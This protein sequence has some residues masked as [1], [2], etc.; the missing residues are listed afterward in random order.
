MNNIDIRSVL[1]HRYPFLLIDRIVE[2]QYGEMVVAVKNVTNN[3]PWTTGHFPE[4]PVYPGVFIFESMAQAGGIL[5]YDFSQKDGSERPRFAWLAGAEKIKFLKPVVPGDILRIAANKDIMAGNVAK[6]SCT[7]YVDDQK[8]A[9][10][11]VLYV[12]E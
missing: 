9:T 5:F 11:R 7:A 8:V 1:R 12:F 10:A 3:E 6:V 4:N 2:H